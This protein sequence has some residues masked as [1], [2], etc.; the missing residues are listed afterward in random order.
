MFFKLFHTKSLK[1]YS[2]QPDSQDARDYLFSEHVSKSNLNQESVDLREYCSPVE[3]QSITNS[4]VSQ[5]LIGNLEFLEKKETGVHTD[6]SRMFTYYTTRV[7][8]C[9]SKHDRGSQIR[10]GIKV[11]KQYGVCKEELHPFTYGTHSLKP[12]QEA[13]EDAKTRKITE[14]YRLENVEDMLECLQ[15]G[16]PVVCAIRLFQSFENSFSNGVVEMPNVGEVTR[17][18]HAVMLVGFSRTDQRFLVRNSWGNL[19]QNQ[20]Y[21]TLPFDYL[22]R[23]ASDCWTIRK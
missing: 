20:G 1:S 21:F 19:I 2:L 16:F 18:L 14:Y 9:D 5:A 4:C 8:E 23:Y 11:L 13:F 3:D 22:T 10:D 7:F 6:L 17:G 12:S 15:Q